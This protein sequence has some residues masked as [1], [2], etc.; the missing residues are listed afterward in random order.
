MKVS[1]SRVVFKDYV[2]V[3]DSEMKRSA[4]AGDGVKLTLDYD[5][6]EIEYCYAGG[7]AYYPMETVSRYDKVTPDEQSLRVQLQ[8][9]TGGPQVVAPTG[10]RASKKRSRRSRKG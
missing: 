5:L 9:G 6:R 4:M 7:K 2:L 3:E 10:G 8:P 1:L